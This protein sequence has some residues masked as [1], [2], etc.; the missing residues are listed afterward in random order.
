LWA[1]YSPFF[2]LGGFAGTREESTQIVID[3][4]KRYPL[5]NLKL[6]LQD[7]AEQFLSFKTGDQIEPQ[8]WALHAVFA[9][10]TPHQVQAYMAARQQRGLL[11]FH[12]LNL[13]HVPVGYL[14]LLGLTGLLGIAVWCREHD[15]AVFVAFVLVGLLANALIC[16]ALSNPH[17]RYQSR[18]MW[19]APFSVALGGIR[20]GSQEWARSRN[21]SSPESAINSQIC[22]SFLSSSLR[23]P[24]ESGT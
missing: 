12:D 4:L 8:Q 20:L 15:T 3:S 21:G 16:G 11:R 13:V 19:L 22:G 9:A 6:A 7:G 18:L 14:S 24:G 17:D 2:K 10:F 5:L 1:P 23:E